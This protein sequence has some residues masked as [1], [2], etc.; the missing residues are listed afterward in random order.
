M[1]IVL[2]EPYIDYYKPA[3]KPEDY[4]LRNEIIEF[5]P[6]DKCFIRVVKP[7]KETS[8]VIQEE[9]VYSF[10]VNGLKYDVPL[11]LKY[12]AKQIEEAKVILDYEDDWDDEGAVA[13]DVNTFTKAIDFVVQYSVFIYNSYKA[14]LKEPYIDILRDGTISVHWEASKNNQMLIIFKKDEGEI[15][16]YYAQQGDRK[17]PLKSAIIPGEQVDETLALWMMKYLC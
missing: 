4:I 9:S 17:I 15:A 6:Q 2:S 1:G 12:I 13:T 11:C 5:T 10:E 3:I 8:D 7:V 16:Y 14:I